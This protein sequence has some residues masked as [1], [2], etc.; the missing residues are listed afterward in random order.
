MV[1]LET[2]NT[3]QKEA[4]TFRKGAESM[5]KKEK[6]PTILEEFSTMRGRLGKL[7]KVVEPWEQG[8]KF[9]L[10]LLRSDQMVGDRWTAFL[11]MFSFPE[12]RKDTFGILFAL[13]KKTGDLSRLTELLQAQRVEYAI[14][15]FQ[16]SHGEIKVI[17]LLLASPHIDEV[18]TFK[19]HL[20]DIMQPSEAMHGILKPFLNKHRDIR[21]IQEAFLRW[22]VACNYLLIHDLHSV[23]RR[24]QSRKK[25]IQANVNLAAEARKAKRDYV[26][27][28]RLLKATDAL[29]VSDHKHVQKELKRVRT[30]IRELDATHYLFQFAT[31]PGIKGRPVDL[32]LYSF[33]GSVYLAVPGKILPPWEPEILSLVDQIFPKESTVGCVDSPARNRYLLTSFER[34]RK[35][36]DGS[37]LLDELKHF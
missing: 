5:A 34:F 16:S 9:N 36:H 24:K 19:K 2:G 27:Y 29:G 17:D 35:G 14:D 26:K 31:P 6:V 11:K 37:L 13:L 10:H 28:E 12:F 15:E 18:V 4:E 1:S 23:P 7:R 32:K 22:L 8:V 21:W 3:R 33:L 20:V 25:M 30:A